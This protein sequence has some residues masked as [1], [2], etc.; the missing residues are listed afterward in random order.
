VDGRWPHLSAKTLRKVNAKM[1]VRHRDVVD[2]WSAREDECG[3]GVDWADAC[4]RCWRCGR[5]AK[6]ELCHIVPDSRGGLREPSNLVLLCKRCHRE[7]PNVSDPQYMWM[8][9]RA[10]CVPFY[11]TFWLMRAVD[12]YVV[13][14]GKTPF[15]G[16][17]GAAVSVE[18]M[19]SLFC[20]MLREA[21]VHF[22]EGHLNPVTVACVIH[23]VE[24]GLQA[25]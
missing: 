13:I 7:A 12:Q 1:A 20:Q 5:E 15:E 18:E 22:G 2:Y 9:L 14:F 4:N 25:R 19:K 17:D 23:Q 8:W 10:T 3:L 24:Q 16:M 21:V 11:D 6:L